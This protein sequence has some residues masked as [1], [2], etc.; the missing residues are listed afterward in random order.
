MGDDPASPLLGG[1]RGDLVVGAPQLERAGRLKVLR[2]EVEEA[3][4][5]AARTRYQRR[6]ERHAADPA[7]R[8]P[9]VVR[10]DHQPPPF[11]R[12]RITSPGAELFRLALSL[13]E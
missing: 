6:A 7:L 10:R 13:V 8:Q 4:F 12:W 2:L 3:V 11:V 5:L 1:E 9:E